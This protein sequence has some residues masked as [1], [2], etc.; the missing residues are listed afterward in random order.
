MLD[1]LADDISWDQSV[2]SE[3]NLVKLSDYL[4]HALNNLKVKKIFRLCCT[5]SKH[6]GF[7]IFSLCE[8]MLFSVLLPAHTDRKN[9][10]P[11]QTD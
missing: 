8:V 11:L 7:L 10:C 5:V 2:L 1:P 6:K 3:V 4:E 9:L